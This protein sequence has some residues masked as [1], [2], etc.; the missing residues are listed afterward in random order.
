MVT[1]NTFILVHASELSKQLV[2][3]GYIV[4]PT[5]HVNHESQ[6]LTHSKQLSLTEVL[7]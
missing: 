7:I 5:Q 2:T 3:H 4:Q 1:A 6:F